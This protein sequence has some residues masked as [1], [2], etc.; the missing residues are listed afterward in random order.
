VRN[1]HTSTSYLLGVLVLV[2]VVLAG[3]AVLASAVPAEEEPRALKQGPVETP[4]PCPESYPPVADRDAEAQALIDNLDEALAAAHKV[5][6]PD[7]QLYNIS[8]FPEATFRLF[9]FSGNYPVA[10]VEL[11]NNGRVTHAERS[12]ARTPTGGFT[13][14]AAIDDLRLGP[15]AAITVAN[16]QQPGAEILGASLWR[17]GDCSLAWRVGLRTSQRI[18]TISIDN[19]TGEVNLRDGPPGRS[20]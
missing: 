6:G 10:R 7:A 9:Y 1:R 8:S 12:T 2:G 11:D 16:A 15:S 20:N 4:V 13:P 19:A 5:A 14:I 3:G 18:F 17:I